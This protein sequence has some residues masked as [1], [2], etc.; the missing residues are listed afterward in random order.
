M[1]GA[2]FGRFGLCDTACSAVLQVAV[3]HFD[4]YENLL[5]Q[6]AGI[7]HVTLFH[8]GQL[9]L[10]YPTEMEEHQWTRDRVDWDKY[11]VGLPPCL[12]HTGTPA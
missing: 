4:A 8:P 2:V 11:T 7:K 6:F 10:L 3:A 9:P 12:P 1:I 5:C